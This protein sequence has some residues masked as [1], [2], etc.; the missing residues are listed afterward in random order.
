MLLS[1]AARPWF[2]GGPFLFFAWYFMKRLSVGAFF[3]RW[4][5]GSFM[6][7]KKMILAK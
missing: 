6:E 7:T 1:V 2:T 4:Q 5:A 3:C